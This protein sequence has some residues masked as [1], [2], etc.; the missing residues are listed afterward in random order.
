M[1]D[2]DALGR[3]LRADEGIGAAILFGSAA[4]EHLRPGSDVDVAVRFTD[5]RARRAFGDD[6]VDS[7]GRLGLSAGRDV[8]L[9]DLERVDAA[10]ARRVLAEGKP[11]F[12]RDPAETRRLFARRLLEYFDWS[13]ARRVMDDRLR[14][15]LG[16]GHG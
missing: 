1:A 8:H 9:V 7:L 11:L 15:Q 3:A 6:L 13:Y 16:A 2:I 5:D 14:E 12:D 4:R 10:L